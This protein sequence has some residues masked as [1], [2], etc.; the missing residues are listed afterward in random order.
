MNSLHPTHANHM[1]FA[2][3]FARDI[4]RAL[5][6]VCGSLKI[7]SSIFVL[8]VALAT[9]SA[10]AQ[11]SLHLIQGSDDPTVL[12]PA[13]LLAPS[14][15]I[16]IA[17]TP[18]FQGRVG[19]GIDPN[20]AQSATYTNFNL[21]PSSGSTPTLVLP[22]GIFLTSGT[23]NIP[24]TN[25]TNQFNPAFPGSGSNAQ[26]SA[27]SG[28]STFDANALSL[29]FTV[30]SGFTSV[31]ANFVFGTDEFP[32]QVVTD[33]FG[34]FVDGVNYAKFPNGDLISNTPGN[35][36]NFI[37]NPV[38]GGLYPIEYNGL[39]QVFNVVGILDP[40]LTTHTLTIGIADTSDTIFDSGVFI[41]GL[42][43]GTATG[44]G[45]IGVPDAGATLPLLGIALAGLGI[46]RRKLLEVRK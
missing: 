23:A 27:L 43:A 18:V 15:G 6:I 14:S 4:S 9:T 22:N 19:D 46:L 8:A 29:S 32:T 17:G 10:R 45:G 30:A 28:A 2:L 42:T 7:N 40:A 21:A 38:G 31:S 26:L 3:L 33:I 24:M 1:S 36:T 35:P 41:G 39:T 44:G 13:S 16:T 11:V 34:F 25:T 20:T 37:S 12:L 5:N